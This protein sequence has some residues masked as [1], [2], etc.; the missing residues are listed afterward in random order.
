[1]KKLAQFVLLGFLALLFTA[2]TTKH[3]LAVRF[4]TQPQGA[5]ITCNGRVLGKTPLGDD[6]I[7]AMIVSNMQ[8]LK[9]KY[10]GNLALPACKAKWMSGYE[11]YFPMQ[12]NLKEFH[13]VGENRQS[14]DVIKNYLVTKTL[15]RKKGQGYE[16]DFLV[17]QRLKKL[18]NVQKQYSKGYELKTNPA[19]AQIFCDGGY[20]NFDEVVRTGIFQIPKCKARWISGYE[21]AFRDRVN[22]DNE[23]PSV[24][25]N[26]TLNRPN[27]KGYADD[28]RWALELEKKQILEANERARTQA[29][30]A[31]VAAQQR[32]AAAAEAQ[33]RAAQKQAQTADWQATM[34]M[35]SQPTA[36]DRA[37]QQ[38]NEMIRNTNDYQRNRSLQGID[39]SLRGIDGSLDSI[40]RTIRRW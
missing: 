27:T 4:D 2:C 28:M 5:E 19:G 6:K 23:D 31:Q 38:S 15:T 8:E 40:D 29:L 10:N 11:D 37:I 7:Q 25:L 24:L 30:Q 12:A 39:K 18:S 14:G 21:M 13:F 20:N 33:A 9:T 3:Q 1:M 34:Q 36:T 22:I 35:L 32:A 26:Q 16:Y 17:E